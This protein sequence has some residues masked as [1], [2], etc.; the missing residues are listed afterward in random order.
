[1]LDDAT[2]VDIDHEQGAAARA[3]QFELTFQPGHND[4]VH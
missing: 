4:R 3:R 1:M 2:E